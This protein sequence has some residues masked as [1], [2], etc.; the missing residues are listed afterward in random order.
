MSF[1]VA[2][3]S[4]VP[5]LVALINASYRSPGGEGGWTDERE[6][7]AGTRTNE[8][9]VR[10]ELLAGRYLVARTI[11]SG[12]IVGCA[13]V[14]LEED[15]AWYVAS[16][17]VDAVQQGAGTGR[18]LLEEI[19]R[20]AKSK[21]VYALRITVINLRHELIAW[22][23]RR[24]FERTGENEQFPYD[25]PTVGRA[26]RDDLSLVVLELSL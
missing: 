10:S 11:V 21:G 9:T 26:L 4:D 15:G 6:F 1:G 17:A 14:S 23:E 25:D 13:R 7:I 20:Q 5:E 18:R 16:F 8:E 19:Q 24:G 22:Y 3:L 2:R 12:P